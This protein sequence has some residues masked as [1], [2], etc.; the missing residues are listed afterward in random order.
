M[1]LVPKGYLVFSIDDKFAIKLKGLYLEEKRVFNSPTLAIFKKQEFFLN[2]QN[3]GL[4]KNRTEPNRKSNSNLVWFFGF[5]IWYGSIF[6][7]EVKKK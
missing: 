6:G 3:F 4:T 2:F 1:Y 5:F 7:F